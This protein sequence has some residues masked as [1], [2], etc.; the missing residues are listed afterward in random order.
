MN[1]LPHDATMLFAQKQCWDFFENY[2]RYVVIV[3]EARAGG[4]TITDILD[5]KARERVAAKET[6]APKA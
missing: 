5:G 6:E 1:A 2:D 4:L 3:D